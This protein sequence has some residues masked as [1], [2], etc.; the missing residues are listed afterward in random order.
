MSFRH[1]RGLVAGLAAAGLVLG[2]L[3]A[4]AA[5][6]AAAPTRYEAENATIS[7][8]VLETTHTGFSGTGYV[9]CDNVAGSYVQW[10]VTMA[11]AGTASVSIRYSNGTA[12]DRVSDITVNGFLAMSGVSF[13]ATTNWDTWAT[14]T[15]TVPVNS[16]ANTIRITGTTANGPAN[17]DYLD[18][19]LLPAYTDYQAENATISQGAVATNH[20]GYT[21]TGFVDYTNVAGSYV[22][23]AVTGAVAGTAQITFHYSN[24]TA[25]DRPMDVS[26][27][28]NV[29]ANDLSFPAT[30]NW[31]TW[32]D[33]TI[34]VTLAA[35][36]NTIRATATTANGGPNL[37]RLRVT[38]Q[39]D[40]QAPTTP[41][42][43][44]CSNITST[45]LTLT[46]PASSDNV[47][48]S[49]YDVYN[50]GNK[51][52]SVGG[53]TPS[54][55][56]TG[57]SPNTEYHLSVFA[58]DA[59]GNVSLSSA[60]AYCTTLPSSDTQAPTAPTGL[61]QSN[62][63]AST[64]NLTWTAS[65][66]NV[67]V[68]AYDVVSGGTVVQTFGKVTS[69][70]VTALL[71]N[72]SYTLSLVARDAGG[73]VSAA[74]NAVTFSTTA[75]G[76]GGFPGTPSTFSSGWTIPWG[77]YF[78]PDGLS[79]LVTERDDKTT[80][81]Q[82]KV[83]KLTTGG[84][85]TQVGTVPNVVTTDGEGGLLGVAFDPNWDTNHYVYFMHTASEGN[86]IVRMT[87]N[88]STLT[89]Y[90]ILV[91]GI[92][93][94]RYHNGGRLAFGPDGYLYATTGDAQSSSNAQNKSSLNGKVL[95]MKTDGTPAPGNPFGTLVYSYGHRNPQG[96]AWD[97]Q[98][99][100][101]EAEFGDSM[102][103]ELNLIKPGNN[104]GWPTCEGT[105]SVAGMTN[106][107]RQWSVSTASPSGIAIVR[108]VVYM[109][110]LRGT[111]LWRIPLLSGEST[112]SPTAYYVGTYGRLRTVTKVPGADQIWLSTT[113]C[114]NNGGQANGSD[115]IY[116]I[117]IS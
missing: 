99:R 95:R 21:G 71:C 117:I 83:Y 58:R 102:Y 109:A 75:C 87:Y 59:A 17:L 105:C 101:W 34:S 37:D 25:V 18:V 39:S 19:D 89:A 56:L 11:S 45:S 67:G 94:N 116:K 104:Y 33:T 110:A 52:A 24:G 30:T 69:G 66:D 51:L 74:S 65:T 7:Q 14:K 90:T 6:A 73:N 84:T 97:S 31:D 26:V 2:L 72:T 54:A 81:G 36:S 106:P 22:E 80:A 115:K 92:A 27:N 32:T 8:G 112:G 50:D 91:Q 77:T 49:A 55:D 38:Q 4:G 86:R 68:T 23:F 15:V 46:W 85:K 44:A 5:P 88:G 70:Q 61:A 43:P 29:A 3:T 98:G 107:A 113:N 20:L 41:G 93:K 60:Q 13:P 111:R 53:T 40:S 108:D 47:S 64:V 76:S 114:D 42:Q 10:T 62:A 12:V 28:G 100:L 63:T 82:F 16:G 9:N 35:G 103:D 79:A 57:L 48:V 1:Q 96:L 78:A